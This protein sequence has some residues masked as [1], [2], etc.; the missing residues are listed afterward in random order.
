MEQPRKLASGRYQARVEDA[1]GKRINPT[2]GVTYKTKKE[3]QDV[4]IAWHQETDGGTVDTSITF[5]EYAELVIQARRGSKAEG[6]LKNEERYI[7][8]WLTPVFGDKRLVNIRHTT[9]LIWFNSLPATSS[10]R[11][12]YMTLSMVLEHALRDGII[13]VKPRL[14]DATAFVGEKKRVFSSDE[15]WA[16]LD[17]LPDFVR[18]FFL[19][20]WGGALRISEALGLDWDAVDLDRGIVHVRQQLLGGHIKTDLKTKKSK[21]T[22]A[23]TEDAVEALRALRKAHPSIGATPVFLNPSTGLRLQHGRAYDLWKR[24]RVMAGIPDIVPHALRRNDLNS[25]RLAVGGDMVRTMARGGHGDHRSALEYQS[26]ELDLDVAA[27]SAMKRRT[28]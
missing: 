14:K 13:K 7:R 12:A 18:T 11:S 8:K 17:E 3:A 9:I 10:R 15:I 21:R 19:I 2:P 27:L 20:Q 28:S 4:Q 25:Y 5:A 26:N 23:L 6:T 1:N 24:A 22:V 16:V